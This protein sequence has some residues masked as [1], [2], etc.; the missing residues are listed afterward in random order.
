MLHT[1]FIGQVVFIALLAVSFSHIAAAQSVTTYLAAGTGSDAG[2]CTL[3]SPCRNLTYALTQT[4]AGGVITIIDSGEFAPASILKAITI[5][6]APGVKAVINTASGN[7]LTVAAATTD[8]VLL[9]GLTLEGQGTANFGIQSTAAGGVQI[10][11]CLVRNF[12]GTGISLAGNAGKHSISNTTVQNCNNGI[13][14][15]VTT[16]TFTTAFALIT[17]CR[18]EKIATTG[19]S[20]S[21]NN[22]GNKTL[23][24][25]RN[26]VVLQCA[27]IGFTANG[28]S[29][30]DAEMLLESCVASNNGTG[31]QSTS[32]A[33]ARV[34]NCVVTGNTLAL[35]GATGT[36]RTRGNNTIEY[37]TTEG[38]FTANFSAK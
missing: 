2:Q 12:A 16:A 35:S 22:S 6:A 26:T 11:N 8:F 18:V 17:N 15:S 36:L 3:A 4:Q 5:Q 9:R 27:F 10:D 23:A 13:V 7:A 30:A 1:K 32:T 37:N 28:N 20:I 21:A 19:I 34:T 25:I 31:I 29:G 38:A 33:K 14:A 24:V